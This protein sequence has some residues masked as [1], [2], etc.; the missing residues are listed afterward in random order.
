MVA[1]HDIALRKENISAV[2]DGFA[3]QVFKIKPLLMLKKSTA[4][5]NTYFQ[6]SAAEL[7]GGLG[8]AVKGVPPLA[9][10]PY[11]AKTYTEKNSFQV[12]HGMEQ[13]ISMEAVRTSEIDQIG[14]TLL[15]I[16]R[17]VTNSVDIDAW[18]VI[19]ENQSASNLNSVSIT[20]GEEWD[21]S[22]VAN[23]N[24]L[25]NLLE[26][27]QKIE[28]NQYDWEGGNGFILVNPKDKRNL[29]SNPNVRN[30]GQFFTD[31]VT[32]NGVVGNLLG[33]R[34]ISSTVITADFAFVGIAKEIGNY[35]EVWPLM[36]DVI[37]DPQIGW[38]VRSSELGITELTNPK[39]GTLIDNTAA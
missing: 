34:L 9:N 11:G 28:E 5:K 30:A 8:S 39:A 35:Q 26:A 19:S 16:S 1:I 17:A 22:N 37:I 31:A 12:K 23:R 18:N 3:N 2:V 25:D 6:E 7:T 33:G 29:L 27:I 21:S 36:T 20:A 14:R 13:T 15:S 24:P 32:R 10:F 38:T 4:N